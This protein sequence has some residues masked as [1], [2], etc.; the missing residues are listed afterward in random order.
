MD[1]ELKD[2]TALITGASSGIGRATARACYA[3]G[4][5]VALLGRDPQRLQ[6]AAEGM[7]AERC[8]LATA[9]ITRAAETQVVLDR[10]AACW[11]GLD[12]LVNAAGII[13]FGSIETESLDCIKVP[14]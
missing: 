14:A 6:E 4:A 2:K 1:L 7:Q 8:L 10:I 9:D 5:R 13:G 11:G 12:I 3:Q